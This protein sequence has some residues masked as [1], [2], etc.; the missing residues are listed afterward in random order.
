MGYDG[1]SSKILQT[2]GYV[3]SPILSNIFNKSMQLGIFPDKLKIAKVIPIH[4]GGKTDVINNY[5]P[6]SILSSLSKIYEK[7]TNN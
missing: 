3:I 5:R 7:I 1:I 2:L 6:I 4:K